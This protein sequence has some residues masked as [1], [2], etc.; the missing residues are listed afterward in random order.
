MHE[1]AYRRLERLAAAGE[2]ARALELEIERYPE[3]DRVPLIRYAWGLLDDRADPDRADAL[4]LHAW[5][6]EERHGGPAHSQHV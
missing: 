3:A 1:H 4:W 2:G 6:V 5:V